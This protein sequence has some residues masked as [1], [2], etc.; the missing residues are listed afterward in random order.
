VPSSASS[1][2]AISSALQGGNNAYPFG[3]AEQ[4]VNSSLLASTA[5]A[6]GLQDSYEFTAIDPS[7]EASTNVHGHGQNS[8]LSGEQDG[9]KDED[10]LKGTNSSSTP[11]GDSLTA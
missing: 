8:L 1:Y 6:A 3:T 5:A 9:V 4:A 11:F 10:G 2:P 7:L